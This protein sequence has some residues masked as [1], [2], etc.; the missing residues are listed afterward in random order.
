MFDVLTYQRWGSARMLQQHL[1]EEQF[2]MVCAT[3]QHTPTE[4]PKPLTF[5][6]RSSQ[7]RVKYSS[8][9]DGFMDLASR[10]PSDFGD[11]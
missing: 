7:P 1:G 6:M 4:I 3:T 5:G 8:R 9:H 10:L 2:A 11:P